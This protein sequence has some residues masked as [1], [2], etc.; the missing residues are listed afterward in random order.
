[1][2]KFLAAVPA[3]AAAAVT[4]TATFAT[5]TFGPTL[6]AHAHTYVRRVNH[7]IR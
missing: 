2:I 1:M 5:T 6:E 4:F 3:F 7:Y